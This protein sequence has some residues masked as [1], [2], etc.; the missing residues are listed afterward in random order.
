VTSLLVRGAEVVVTMDD[1]G[2]EIAGGAVYA[3]DG[4]I[5]QVGPAA[6]LPGT[7]DRVVDASG[8]VVLPG[9]INTHHHLSQ[10]LTRALPG[11][12][13]AG[14]FDW[15]RVLYPVW[16]RL[17]PDHVRTATMTGL[18]EL[19]L[20]G[21][22]TAFDHQYL[23]PG[24]SRLDDQMEAADVIGIRFHGSRGSMSVGESGGGLPP[25]EVVE[26]EDEILEDC[27]RVID[28]FHDAAPGSMRQ[29]AL[30]PCSPFSVSTGLMARTA[31]LARRHGVRLHT[32]LAET[33]DEEEYCRATFGRRP[34]EYAADTGWLGEDVWF[35][36]AVHVDEQEIGRMAE[37]GT[38]VAHCPTSNMRLGSGI[39]PV[40]G[41]MRSGVLVGLGVD[42][43][44]SNDSSHML[45]EV[46]QAMLLARLAGS[47]VPAAGPQMTARQALR[48]ATRGGAAI[49]G[50][51]DIGSLEVGKVCDMIAIDVG[52]IDHAGFA[53]PVAGVVFASPGRVRHTIVHGRLIVEDGRLMSADEAEL[54]A[55]HRRLAAALVA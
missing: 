51:S 1:A 12:Q 42:G 21:C 41:F 16:A 20:S 43:S 9:L 37:T 14:L 44:A 17:T 8:S 55:A 15:L 54:A 2:S 27:V 19:A 49:L 5:R 47:I 38:G 23:W 24:G 40:A 29:V 10:T 45:A 26:D 6:T 34:V 48:L 18:A 46:R 50:R 28:A 53:D 36:H 33:A 22:T 52:G 30:A 13:N 11:A 7:A 3:E 31:E 35:A 4:W 25:D 32:H 39:A